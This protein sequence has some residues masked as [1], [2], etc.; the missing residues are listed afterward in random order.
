MYIMLKQRA[1]QFVISELVT[2]HKVLSISSSDIWQG[3]H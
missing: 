1:K 3:K 2:K